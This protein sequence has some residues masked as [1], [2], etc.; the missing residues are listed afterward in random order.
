M[1][2][3]P[4][5]QGKYALVDN[6]DFERL[7]QWKWFYAETYSGYSGYATR[8]VKIEDKYRNVYMHR[9]IL[10]CPKSLQVDHI[11]GNTLDNRKKNIRLCN[12]S[13]NIQNSYKHRK[14]HLAGVGYLS[15]KRKKH[16][17][18]ILWNGKTNISLGTFKTKREAHNTWLSYRKKHNLPTLRINQLNGVAT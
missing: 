13:E 3:V 8:K 17:S 10:N 12:R 7:N 5:T 11:N 14:G 15:G 2:R 9:Y 16:F 4:L 6:E 1:K 18:A